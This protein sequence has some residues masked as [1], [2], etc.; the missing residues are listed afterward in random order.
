MTPAA[1]PSVPSS[2][3]WTASGRD[4]NLGRTLDDLPRWL[5]RTYGI[6]ENVK[7]W[8]A[9]GD[10]STDDYQAIQNCID[11]VKTYG[12]SVYFPPGIYCI[13][14]KLRIGSFGVVT[15]GVVL[16]GSGGTSKTSATGH[17]STWLK[18]TGTSDTGPIVD[19]YSSFG[20]EI[21]NIGFDGN[22]LVTD[23]LQISHI[24]GQTNQGL[25]K[26]VRSCSFINAR[27]YSVLIGDD[28][29]AA[30]TGQVEGV[31]FYNCWFRQST[32][33]AHTVAHVRH[34]STNALANNMYGCRFAGD[35]TYPTHHVSVVSGQMS[36]FGCEGAGGCGT[37]DFLLGSIAGQEPG[38]IYVYG[39]ESQGVALLRTDYSNTSAAAIR[40]TVLS[41]VYSGDSEGGTE[42]AIIWGTGM[43]AVTDWG[44]LVIEGGRFKEDIVLDGPLA[45]VFATG[46]AFTDVS[47]AFDAINGAV[48]AEQL[49]ARWYTGAAGSNSPH[50]FSQSPG[51]LKTGSSSTGSVPA[52]TLYD[53]GAMWFDE[54]LGKLIVSD[55]ADWLA[56]AAW[57]KF[58]SMAGTTYI[59]AGRSDHFLTIFTTS[60]QAMQAPVNAVVGKAISLDIYNGTG[61]A[62]TTTW[63]A[64]FK[65][66]GAWVD[67][68]N[69]KRRTITFYYDGTN[70]VELSRAAADI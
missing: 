68:A 42:A 40:A 70:W 27:R 44:P 57:D 55:G 66:A 60:P 63:N 28:T 34:V 33:G 1:L 64:V 23:L 13:S 39:Y 19:W 22:N 69:T 2:T 7:A 56:P 61:G 62:L 47:G 67:P 49:D 59:D 9:L 58:E 3:Y 18:Y 30:K 35:L 20:G 45:K 54:S 21:N 4:E 52:A 26:S 15:E 11:Y 38:N 25:D 6:W 17:G 53:P 14:Q 43:T 50:F 32:L 5:G 41:G 16:Q 65:L 51:A 8:G 24:S 46:V 36:F 12:G 31:N 29:T 10:G 48:L 37:S